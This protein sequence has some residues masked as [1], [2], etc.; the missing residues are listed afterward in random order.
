MLQTPHPADPL[1]FSE[2]KHNTDSKTIIFNNQNGVQIFAIIA[3]FF[4]FQIY[5]VSKSKAQTYTNIWL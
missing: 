4:F 2:L 1:C 5:T 3:D